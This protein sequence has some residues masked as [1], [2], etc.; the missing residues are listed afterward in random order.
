M[1][2]CRY[3]SSPQD[4]HLISYVPLPSRR[5]IRF[6]LLSAWPFF[7]PSYKGERG[8]RIRRRDH[9][10]SRLSVCKL[11]HNTALTGALSLS[12]F[13]RTVGR[14]ATGA[15]RERRKKKG[16]GLGWC[17]GWKMKFR[18]EAAR[19]IPFTYVWA[20]TVRIKSG[21]KERERERENAC[22]RAAPR[23]LEGR[24]NYVADSYIITDVLGFLTTN[25]DAS[26]A[27]LALWSWRETR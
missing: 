2:R 14:R 4:V 13:L 25:R 27:S 12:L 9:D 1:R 3:P 23:E 19:Q 5:H 7:T 21:E 15:R 22:I 11:W 10:E 20:H 18:G 16:R 24:A 6:P 26:S 8:M 17:G